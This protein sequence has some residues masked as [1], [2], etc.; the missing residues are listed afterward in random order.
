LLTSLARAEGSFEILFEDQAK[1]YMELYSKQNKKSWMSD[2]TSLNHL[3]EYFKGK[4]LSEITAE[5]IEKYKA[6]RKADLARPSLDK[7]KQTPSKLIS[8][9]ND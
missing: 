4:Y 9:G 5:Q 6:K 7:S 1:E 3:K 8:P 2:E